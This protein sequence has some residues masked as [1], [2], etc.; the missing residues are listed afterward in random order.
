M[1]LTAL[2]TYHSAKPKELLDRAITSVV[3]YGLDYVLVTDDVIPAGYTNETCL[4]RNY[5][6]NKSLAV[7]AILSHTSHVMKLDCDDYLVACPQVFENV[8]CNSKG[9]NTHRVSA[10]SAA[11]P[12]GGTTIPREIFIS[13]AANNPFKFFEDLYIFGRLKQSGLKIIEGEYS[14]YM[15]D[16]ESCSNR[17]SATKDSTEKQIIKEQIKRYLYGTN[18]DSVFRQWKL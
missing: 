14:W 11:N 1:G 16:K 17:L 8:A 15:Y 7:A 6:L 2:I 18:S 12:L 3:A 10:L 13:A 4:G 5:G 9:T